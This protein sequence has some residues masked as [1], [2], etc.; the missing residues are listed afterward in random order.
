MS[1]VNHRVKQSERGKGARG[2]NPLHNNFL[3]LAL[4]IVVM[5]VQ[6]FQFYLYELSFSNIFITTLLTLGKE[7]NTYKFA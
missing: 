7:Q 5:I 2:A 1:C 3:E 6:I 4:K